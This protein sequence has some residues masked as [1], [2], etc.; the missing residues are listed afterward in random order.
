MRKLTTEEFVARAKSIHGEKYDYSESIYIST[1]EKLFV[2]CRVHGKFLVSPNK[3][4]SCKQG[5]PKCS[6]QQVKDNLKMPLKTFISK[7]N[8]VHFNKYDYSRF[9]YENYKTKSV[10]ICP[11]HGAFTQSPDNHLKGKGCPECARQAR[12]KGIKEF[13]RQA[14]MIHGDKYDY[15]LAVYKNAD[16]KVKIAC[17]IH[18]IFMQRPSNHLLL[19]QGCPKCAGNEAKDTEQFKKDAIEIHGY[20]YDYRNSIY[21]SN[22]RKLKIVCPIHGDFL[23]TP[24]SHLAGHGCPECSSSKGEKRVRLFLQSN[25]L[26]YSKEWAIPDTR[27]R[28]DFFLPDRSTIIEYDGRQHFQPIEM[29]GGEKA[30]KARQ[31]RD[32]R[33][34]AIAEK[35]GLKMIRIPYWDYDNIESILQ[36]HLL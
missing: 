35:M 1:K 32:S 29:F 9:R 20:R 36:K 26:I 15:S 25:K 24:N 30:F 14:K 4:I 22:N 27:L 7:S 17:K 23:Q 18:G 6:K 3:H 5:C 16:T 31:K 2:S 8:K 13:V 12:V 34:N 19:S 21:R 33:K 28:C 10:I 11:K